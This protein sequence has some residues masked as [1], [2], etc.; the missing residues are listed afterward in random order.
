MTTHPLTP[1]PLTTSM[2]LQLADA[3]LSLRARVAHIALLLVSL[4]MTA[5]IVSLWVTEPFLPVRTQVAFGA[6][7]II[8]L[9]WTVFAARV[10]AGRRVLYARHRVVA[11][12][13]A[14]AFT[15]VFVAGAL[16]LGWMMQSAA[17]YLAAG[18]GVLMLVAA[19]LLLIRAQ[20]ALALLVERHRALDQSA[21]R[22]R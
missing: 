12:R 10:L 21:S 11:G 14:V 19:G 13:M 20:R 3:E 4:L 15:T 17:G 18:I 16:V 5:A 1:P 22:A 6:I 8:G 7:T 2:L 9:S